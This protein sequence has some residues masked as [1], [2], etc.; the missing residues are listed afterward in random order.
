ML[1]FISFGSGS[2]G[3]CY[4]L[5]SETDGLLIDVGIG[6][7]A[8]KKGFFQNGLRMDLVHN[9]LVTHDHADHIKS[10]GKVSTDYNI[11][12]YST[13]EVHDGIH[14]NF[15]VHTKIPSQLVRYLNKG[16]TIKVGDFVV[17]PF[18]VP[19]DSADNVGYSV[20]Y[21]GINFC[22]VTD[23]GE[24]TA[25]IRHHIG[26]AQYLVIESNHDE[27][28]VI[29]G[30]YPDYLKKRILGNRG[31]LSNANCGLALA[32][33]MTESLRVVWLCHLSEENNHP[34]LARKTVDTTLRSYGIVAGQ[35]IQLEVLGRK[36]PSPVFTLSQ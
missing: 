6:I 9:I 21:K 5:F 25:D 15:Y 29:S 35:D 30:K 36:T 27:Q 18:A 16:V 1:K 10:V 12:V 14:R 33:N 28:M 20:E 2:S 7:R 22:L 23:I 3:N 13:R 26:K 19:H 17:T 8:L 24:I 32:E 11:P 4:Y 34:E 31:H